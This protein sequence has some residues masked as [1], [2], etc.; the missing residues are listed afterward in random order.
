MKSLIY[1][2]R[3]RQ[4]RGRFPDKTAHAVDEQNGLLYCTVYSTVLHNADVGIN[5][6]ICSAVIEE[7]QPNTVH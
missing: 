6:A 3:K 1:Q 5:N 7:N 4:T 2:Q